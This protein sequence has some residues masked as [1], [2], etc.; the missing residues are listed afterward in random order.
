MN[1][2]ISVSVVSIVEV[3][4]VP[5]KPFEYLS[6]RNNETN[7]AS[8][9][10]TL[11]TLHASKGLEYETVFLPGWEEGLF[12]SSRSLEDNGDIGLEEE[13][14]LAYVAITRAKNLLK[15]FYQIAQLIQRMNLYLF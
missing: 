4:C 6:I 14:R 1:A 11:M 13:R 2:L 3:E 8:G 12:P 5:S 7:N 9:E 15:L 10:V